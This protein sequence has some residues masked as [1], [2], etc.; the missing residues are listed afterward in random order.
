M[1]PCYLTHANENEIS[2]T[3]IPAHTSMPMDCNPKTVVIIWLVY[4]S[5]MYVYNSH[6]A[7]SKFASIQW[8][9]PLLCND[10]SHWMGT[11]LESA[12]ESEKIVKEA[13]QAF[14]V[15]LHF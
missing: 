11:K 2:T 3:E 5:N 4:Y 15:G 1:N 9:T 6:R 14:C 10:V 8:E 13:I 12:L 7:D